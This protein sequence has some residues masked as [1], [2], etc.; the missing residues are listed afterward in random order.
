MAGFSE[1][2]EGKIPEFVK[3]V[4]SELEKSNVKVDEDTLKKALLK[5]QER[6][7]CDAS[8]SSG[9]RW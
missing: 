7:G 8:C 6:L 3:L 9:M 4:K 1:A 5:S 2:A